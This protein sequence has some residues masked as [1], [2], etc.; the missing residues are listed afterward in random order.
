M[1]EEFLPKPT[2]LPTHS[3]STR[4]VGLV[5]RSFRG[6]GGSSHPETVVGIS[7]D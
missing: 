3:A 4:L 5:A 7:V 2:T 1:V 6:Y